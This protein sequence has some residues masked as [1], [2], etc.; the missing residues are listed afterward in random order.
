ME[1][2]NNDVNQFVDLVSPKIEELVRKAIKNQ[3]WKYKIGNAD[4]GSVRKFLLFFRKT[5]KK[6][7]PS[8]EFLTEYLNK[9]FQFYFYRDS[10]AE[11]KLNY[12]RMTWFFGEKSLKRWTD[13][14]STKGHSAHTNFKKQDLHLKEI[15][16]KSLYNLDKTYPFEEAEKKRF[17]NTD[18]GLIWC[19]ENTTMFHSDSQ[20]CDV[21]QHKTECKKLMKSTN[22]KLYDKRCS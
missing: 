22:K 15:Q 2:A 7:F 13:G 4:F 6:R 16:Q 19:Y 3:Y 9:Q 12:V 11:Y 17:L 21:C 10:V 8:E 1:I 14:M 18:A 5:Y 20:V